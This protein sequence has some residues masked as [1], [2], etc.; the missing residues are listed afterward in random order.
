MTFTSRSYSL[1]SYLDE[2]LEELD[3]LTQLSTEADLSDHPQ[4]NLVEP[5][6][7]QVHVSCGS[8]EALA[9]KSVIE[10]LML[11]RAQEKTIAGLE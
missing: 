5:P 6:Q 7:E 3:S 8:S 10:Q 1:C 2:F 4:L 11:G 9:A